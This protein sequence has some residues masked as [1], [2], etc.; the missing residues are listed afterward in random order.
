MTWD[1]RFLRRIDFRTIPILLALMCISILVI[2]ATSGENADLMDEVFLTPLAK[3]QMRWFA[4]GGCVYLFFAGLDY[5]KL[6]QWTWFFYFA[7]LLMLIGLFFV[8]T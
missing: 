8:S 2:A 4:I 1:H 3:S 6:K 7:I 5:R